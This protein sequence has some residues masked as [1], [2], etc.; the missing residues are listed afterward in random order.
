MTDRTATADAIAAVTPWSTAGT[1]APLRFS[2]QH[3]D[4]TQRANATHVCPAEASTSQ[5]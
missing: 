5:A 4:E 2:H 3:T 1:T